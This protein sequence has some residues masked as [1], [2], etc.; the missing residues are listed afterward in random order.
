M[1]VYQLIADVPDYQEFPTV[2]E[3]SAS[4]RDLA[5][6]Y[7]KLVTLQNIGTAFC[8][9]NVY[10]RG[11]FVESLRRVGYRVRDRWEN[12]EFRCHIPFH[13]DKFIRAYSGM[14]LTRDEVMR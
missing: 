4:S 2:Q 13:A 14:Y 12:P 6:R 3:L 11:E 7:P 9:Y 10:N 5:R 8:P 1:D